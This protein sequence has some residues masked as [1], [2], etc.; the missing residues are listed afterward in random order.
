MCSCCFIDYVKGKMGTPPDPDRERD[1]WFIR[2]LLAASAA[3]DVE[4]FGSTVSIAECTHIYGD[5]NDEVKMLF[6]KLLTSGQYIKLVQ[7]EVFITEDARDLR[8]NHGINLHGVDAI[9]V[10]SAVSRECTEFLTTDQ[11][12]GPLREAPK[13]LGA[14]GLRVIHA[15]DTQLLPPKYRQS[16]MDV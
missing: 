15:R 12:K 4:V 11:K 5:L 2:Q 13:I 8:W 10:A 6:R 7:P 3:G 16:L 9:H 14:F 1:L